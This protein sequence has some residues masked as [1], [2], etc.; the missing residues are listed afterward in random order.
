MPRGE[1]A[2]LPKTSTGSALSIADKIDNLIGFFGIG[3]KPTS[4]SDPFA[5]RR[6]ALGVI[7]ILIQNEYSIDL[8]AYIK[9]CIKSF[10]DPIKAKEPEIISEVI[11]FFLIRAKDFLLIWD[12]QKMK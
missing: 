10:P 1:N 8:A 11:S 6:Q 9:E 4:S 5:L 3:L 2:P 7:K 12:M